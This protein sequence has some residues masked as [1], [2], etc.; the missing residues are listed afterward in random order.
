MC[1]G[2]SGAEGDGRPDPSSGLAVGTACGAVV[3]KD[4]ESMLM[5][6][7]EDSHLHSL[8]V[9]RFRHYAFR[10]DMHPLKRSEIRLRLIRSSA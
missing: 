9:S 6:S 1:P 4:L 10:T 8:H 3:T 2:G 5:A 7:R